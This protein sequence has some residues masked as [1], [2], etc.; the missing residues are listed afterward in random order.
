MLMLRRLEEAAGAEE[1]RERQRVEPAAVGFVDRHA[2]KLKPSHSL[3]LS[4]RAA[5]CAAPPTCASLMYRYATKS[6]RS[7]STALAAGSV[8][9]SRHDQQQGEA[10]SAAGAERA[11]AAA[12]AA[13]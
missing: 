6:R 4:Q 12:A 5:H 9:F 3:E 11:A 10:D 2:R 13:R 8:A 1:R 7:V